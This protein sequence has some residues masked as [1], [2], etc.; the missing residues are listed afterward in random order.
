VDSKD[1]GSG[2]ATYR[3]TVDGKQLATTTETRVE[4]PELHGVHR[5]AVVG[6]D[7]AGNRSRPG[8]LLLHIA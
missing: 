7:R 8:T 2:V 4:L 6:I 1:R 5:F 3:V